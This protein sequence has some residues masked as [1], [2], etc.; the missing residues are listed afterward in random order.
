[1][2]I[3][4]AYSDGEQYAT[5]NSEEG[6]DGLQDDSPE[7]PSL[8]LGSTCS[9][10]SI[11]PRSSVESED[12]DSS[13]IYESDASTINR[14]VPSQFA[15]DQ[16]ASSS[17]FNMSDLPSIRTELST[18]SPMPSNQQHSLR[19]APKATSAQRGAAQ[20]PSSLSLDVELVGLPE[21]ARNGR[22]VFLDGESDSSLHYYGVDLSCLSQPDGTNAWTLSLGTTSPFPSISTSDDTPQFGFSPTFSSTDNS[23]T[24]HDPESTESDYGCSPSLSIDFREL[25]SI[26]PTPAYRC[27]DRQ[28]ESSTDSYGEPSPPY[29]AES[30]VLEPIPYHQPVFHHLVVDEPRSHFKEVLGDMKRF[31][32]KLKNIFRSK[33]QLSSKGKAPATAVVE[34]AYQQQPESEID[35]HEYPSTSTTTSVQTILNRRGDYALRTPPGLLGYV[36]EVEEE[37]EE[38]TKVAE[39]ETTPKIPENRRKLFK[40]QTTADIKHIRRRTL[41]AAPPAND[42]ATPSYEAAAPIINISHRRPRPRSLVFTTTAGSNPTLDTGYASTSSARTPLHSDAPLPSPFRDSAEPV[43]LDETAAAARRRKRWSTPF[44]LF[45]RS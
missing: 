10:S 25:E 32:T 34:T 27:N 28:I 21:V 23:T 13:S 14:P 4:D 37:E 19:R 41:P 8:S 3:K 1:M 31:G 11:E 45:S 17:H 29:E 40:P 22:G 30:L 39:Q 18:V 36:Q 26:V 15:L 5:A 35:Y 43:Q 20:C 9:I 16:T 12:H 42:W 38:D 33:P 24:T 6:G 7:A 2:N 44:S